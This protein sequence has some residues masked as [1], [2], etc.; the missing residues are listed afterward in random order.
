M[1]LGS[2]NQQRRNADETIRYA[3]QALAFYQPGGY[4]K[5]TSQGLILLGRANQQKG[6]YAA[7]LQIFEQQLQV[8]NELGEPSQIA[9]SQLSIG[10]L[11]MEQHQYP[12]A[13]SHLDES[14]KIDESL[15]AKQ[16]IGFDLLNRGNVLWLMGRYQEARTDLDKAFSIADRPESGYKRL[17]AEVYL[18]NALMALSERRFPE[19][20]AK[21]QQASELAG[22]QFENIAVQSRYALGLAQALSGAPQAGR[23]LCE[24][25]VAMAKEKSNPGLLAN[26]LLAL[27]EVML[28]AGDSQNAATIAL[29]AQATFARSGRKDSEWHAWLIAARASQ[30]AGNEPAMH[31]YASRAAGLL[32]ELQQN[33]GPEVYGSYLSRPDIQSC[34]QQ[35]DRI[36]GKSK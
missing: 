32:S 5:E 14:Y 15:G 34:R 26:A 33:W 16:R 21:A 12:A 13:L 19:A 30:L 20:K 8:A 27:A 6:D 1:M 31:D 2:L 3:E 22:T 36:L 25:A 24:Q 18:S 17:L 29:Q 10:L 7:A 35:I 28:K 9:S 4:R 23:P 11:L